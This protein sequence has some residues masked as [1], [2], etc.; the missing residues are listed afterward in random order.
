VGLA[1]WQ[2]GRLVS[3]Q[4]PQRIPVPFVLDGP[5]SHMESAGPH[6]FPGRNLETARAAFVRR[7]ICAGLEC[8]S[9]EARSA[10][11]GDQRGRSGL[12]STGDPRR[13]SACRLPACPRARRSVAGRLCRRQA[14]GGDA[15]ARNN[16]KD[17]GKPLATSWAMPARATFSTDGTTWRHTAPGVRTGDR[18]RYDVVGTGGPLWIAWGTPLHATG[19]GRTDCDG[20]E[21]P[22]LRQAIRTGSD[23]RRFAGPRA[24]RPGS[25]PGRGPGN[26]GA[27]PSACL[28]ERR[29]LGGPRLHR[30]VDQ[31]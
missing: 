2:P 20:H 25:R 15:A 3:R 24:A 14:D 1:G 19:Y 10:D 17:T 16:G 8:K 26:L 9:E 27:G 7:A 30:M 18:I 29:E 13:R 11:D 6:Q 31:R 23:A 21:V 28:G 22:A 5:G 4:S 12:R